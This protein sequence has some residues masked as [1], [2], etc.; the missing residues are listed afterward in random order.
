M[1]AKRLS[2]QLKGTKPLFRDPG[3]KRGECEGRRGI[4]T[5]SDSTV[6]TQG[7]D[8]SFNLKEIFRVP[9]R[10]IT[11]DPPTMKGLNVAV[12]AGDRLGSEYTV[13][14]YASSHC[15]LKSRGRRGNKVEV[16]LPTEMLTVVY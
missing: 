6:D 1:T 12:I 4:I 16:T 3:F 13:I 9:A 14:E 15:S 5:P 2:V 8:V 7:A 11:S 10:Y